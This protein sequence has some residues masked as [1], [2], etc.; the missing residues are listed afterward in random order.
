MLTVNKE[1]AKRVDIFARSGDYFSQTFRFLNEDSSD[2]DLTGYSFL[3]KVYHSL[4]SQ[5]YR[6]FTGVVTAN[7]VSFELPLFPKL[8]TLYELES[9]LDSKT[10]DYLKGRLHL[11]TELG[12]E[13]LTDGVLEITVSNTN[14]VVEVIVVTGSNPSS[15]DIL[16]YLLSLPGAAAGKIPVITSDGLGIE[17]VTSGV[18]TSP[19]DENADIFVTT[20]LWIN[21]TLY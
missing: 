4:S 9:T 2:K 16:S 15:L 11:H 10:T 12:E 5:S 21:S 7:E 14:T 18:V 3:L 19:P 1:I 8:T 13:E 20:D 17:W 6:S